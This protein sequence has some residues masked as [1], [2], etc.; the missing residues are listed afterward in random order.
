VTSAAACP[1]GGGAEL[2][3]CGRDNAL[4]VVDVRTFGVLATMRHAAF[5]VGTNF[6]RAAWSPDARHVAAGG[7]DGA[8]CIWQLPAGGAAGEREGTLAATL[9]GHA[10]PVAACA[11]S[12]AAAA[13]LGSCD[14][15]GV[16]LLWEA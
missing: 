4:R 10:A 3:T 5:R 7:A 15:A 13:Q 12:P 11:W 6:A 2:L 16:T 8:V 1:R 14:K 9:R